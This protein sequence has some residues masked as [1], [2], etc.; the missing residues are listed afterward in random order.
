MSLMEVKQ[1]DG[2]LIFKFEGELRT[3]VCMPLQ[4]EVDGRLNALGEDSAT[5]IVFD[6][7]DVPYASSLFMRI[8]LKTVHRV[9][10]DRLA[11]V[12]A[13]PFV[14]GIFR[15]AALQELLRDG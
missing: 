4:D 15:T 12:N 6:L 7:Q 11:V 3:D 10:R 5:R 13:N 8:V 14:Q 2:S 9:G 1:G